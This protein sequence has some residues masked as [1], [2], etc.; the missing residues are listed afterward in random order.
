MGV[1][2][3][4]RKRAREKEMK[5]EKTK[6][7]YIHMQALSYMY[8][9]LA[10]VGLRIHQHGQMQM[11]RDASAELYHYSSGARPWPRRCPRFFLNKEIN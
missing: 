5:K 6:G 8:T 10:P 2:Y 3:R 7:L 11:V 1:R 4:E 9:R